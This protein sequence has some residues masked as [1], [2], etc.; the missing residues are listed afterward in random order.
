MLKLLAWCDTNN[1]KCIIDESF[2]DFIDDADENS[3]LHSN[4]L[5]KYK[6]LVI[7]KSISKSFGVPGFRIGILASSNIQLV[8]QIKDRLPIWNINAFAEFYM[9]IY[10]KYK[11]DYDIALNKFRETRKEFINKLS[12]ITNLRV[13]PTQ[14]NF[15]MCQLN[16][17]MTSAQVIEILLNKYN[18]LAKDLTGKKGFIDN[19][20]LRF[21]IRTKNENDLLI[22]ALK[23]I[24]N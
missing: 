23:N 12:D 24:L 2:I 17:S 19:N 20:Y 6:N 16:N 15:V 4:I 3:L 9:Q 22:N 11:D 10:E 1:I 7:I 21:A 8:N 13:I 14:A 18:I 5:E